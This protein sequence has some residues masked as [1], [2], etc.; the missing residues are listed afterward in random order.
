MK[1]ESNRDDHGFEPLPD[2]IESSGIY[3]YV[4]DLQ[5]RVL[6]VNSSLENLL[7]YPRQKIKDKFLWEVLID[8]EEAG[9]FSVFFEMLQPEDFPYSHENYVVTA[10]GSKTAVLWHESY[11]IKGDREYI[12]GYGMEIEEKKR[13]ELELKDENQKLNNIVEAIPLALI[14]MDKQGRVKDWNLNARKLFGWE[15]SEILGCPNPVI[16][17]EEEYDYRTLYDHVLQGNTVTDYDLSVYHKN[18][19]MIHINLSMSLLRNLEGAVNGFV[20]MAKDVSERKAA[21]K[22][23]V[24]KEA[25]LRMITDSM[26]DLIVR[27]DV[28]GVINYASP[29]HETVLGYRPDR[30]LGKKYM[31]DF[32]KSRK[33]DQDY[34]KFWEAMSRAVKTGEPVKVVYRFPHFNGDIVWLES[35]INTIT[36][37]H[38]KHVVGAVI[39]SREVTEQK[40]AEE[41]LRESEWRHRSI[42]ENTFDMIALLDLKG[43]YLY[44]N[45]AHERLLGYSPEELVGCSAFEVI[46]PEDRGKAVQALQEGLEEGKKEANYIFHSITRGGGE[47]IVDHKIR[48]LEDENGKPFQLLVIATDITERKKAEQKIVEYNQE[49]ENLYRQLDEEVDKARKVHERTLPEKLPRVEGISFSAF[50]QPAAKVGG[51]FYNVINTGKKLII[52]L[53]DVTGHGLEGALLSAFLKEAIDS[54]VTMEEMEEK[55]TPSRVLWHLDSQYRRKKFPE[56]YFI[57][58]FIAVLDLNTMELAYTAA[59]F[60]DAPLVGR[61]N[62]EYEKLESRG[63]PVSNTFPAEMLNFEEKTIALAPGNTVFFN[64]DGLTEQEVEGEKYGERLYDVFQEYFQFPPEI[65]ALAVN[66][67]FLRFNRGLLQGDDDITYLVMQ[68]HP[69]EMKREVLKLRSS[70]KELDR[71]RE[72]IDTSI[73]KEKETSLLKPVLHELAANAIEHGNKFAPEKQVWIEFAVTANYV[74]ASVEDEGEGFNW[75]EKMK[76][77]FEREGNQERGRGIAMIRLLCDYF[78][79]NEKGNKVLVLKKL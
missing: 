45:Q 25:Q 31:R 4:L 11:I 16:P 23:L 54:Y 51:D 55:I 9:L 44:C 18:G 67:D 46:H 40:K 70:F 41:A 27:V 75:R 63:L 47:R 1:C 2:F 71:L 13:D 42:T 48:V 77:G 39:S 60:Q 52:Y 30:I 57:S 56:D 20:V 73:M 62:G 58:I 72:E 37:K 21:E 12:V 28:N 5:G 19:S 7:G 36:S 8:P 22:K 78:S 43:N 3:L 79:Y 68:V 15:S 24:E 64:T 49:L 66:E 59:G 76:T 29:S 61:G 50:Y 26:H 14:I 65:I 33:L 6:A 10:E 74:F 17:L 34:D 53:S 32:Y 69:P 38:S 35:L